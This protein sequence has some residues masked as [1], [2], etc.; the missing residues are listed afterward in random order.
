[1]QPKPEIPASWYNFTKE[2]KDC[3]GESA[4]DMHIERMAGVVGIPVE[5]RKTNSRDFSFNLALMTVEMLK[6]G[7][8][9]GNKDSD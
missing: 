1:M 2:F 8:Q 4:A 3:F 7:H 5:G 9:F 6:K